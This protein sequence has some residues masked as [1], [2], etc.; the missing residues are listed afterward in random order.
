M[1]EPPFRPLWHLLERQALT[2][3]PLAVSLAEI[4]A[5]IA[6]HHLPPAAHWWENRVTSQADAW[7]EAGYRVLRLDMYPDPLVTFAR[8]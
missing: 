6:P 7:L 1:I 2:T 4:E 8:L 3:T 5:I